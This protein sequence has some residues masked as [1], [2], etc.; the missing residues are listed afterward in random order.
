LSL[1]TRRKPKIAIFDVEGVLIPENR[2]LFFEVGRSLGFLKSLRLLFYGILYWLGIASLK[3][4]MKHVFRPLKGFRI[5]EL[6]QIFRQIPLVPGMKLVFEKIRSDG[7]R[8][9]LISSGLPTLV[10]K[11]LALTLNADKAFGFELEVRNGVFTGEIWG[12]VIERDGKL[13]VL[14][15]LLQTE[16]L[17]AKDCVVI[18][19]DRNNA[20]IMLPEALKIGYNPDFAVRMKADH[21]VVG[22]PHEILSLMNSETI[23]N[24]NLP[25]KNQVLRETIHACGFAVP[26]LS[27]I[28]GLY[29]TVLLILLITSLYML[30]ELLMME[31]KTLPIVSLITRHAAT[32]E[33]I[34][35]FRTSPIFFAFGI[36]LTLLFFPRQASGAAIAA[37]ALGDSTASIFGGMLGRK[38]LPYNKGKTLEGSLIGFLFAFL[39]AAFFVNPIAALLGAAVA[40]LIESMPLPLNDNLLVP[41]ITGF[42][43]TLAV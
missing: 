30:S 40:M 22:R 17:T 18:A 25:T 10:V 31:R 23:L 42:V 21:V 37:F 7:C 27:G 13:L 26:L 16:K 33:E 28:V 24:R 19:D 15:K 39:A 5:D 36:L 20:S 11:D 12:D 35:G 6:L 3:S 1:P 9:A 34:Y 38:T 14:R 4:T 29:P 2:Y 43:L 8:T 32:S 41:L